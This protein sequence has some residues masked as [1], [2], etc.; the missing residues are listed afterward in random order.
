MRYPTASRYRVSSPFNLRRKHPVTG[1]IAP[2]YGV[3]FATPIGTPVLSTGDGVVSRTGNHPFAG[4]YIE[5][6]HH[7]QFKTRYLHLH[8]IQV[9]RGQAV[10]RGDRIA[11][12]G[13]T[14]RSTGPHLHF[15]LHVNN[16][17]VDPLQAD[18]P[19]AR[20]IPSE[21]MEAFRANVDR[22]LIAMETPDIPL[23]QSITDADDQPE[24]G[25]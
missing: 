1:R 21:E 2:H 5:I 8:E 22:L 11:L 9:T 16:R 25:I 18:I 14:G 6:K 24:S 23:A 13:N 12:S 7:G 19:K 15:E 17:P 4:K 20:R 10:Q 3:D